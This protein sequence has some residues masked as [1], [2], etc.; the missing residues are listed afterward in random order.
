MRAHIVVGWVFEA[1]TINGWYSAN[2]SQSPP[3]DYIETC[4]AVNAWVQM[5]T[6]TECSHHQGW[7]VLNKDCKREENYM[8]YTKYKKSTLPNGL[9]LWNY[10]RHTLLPPL[11]LYG[12]TDKMCSW[13]EML[14]FPF[15]LKILRESSFKLLLHRSHYWLKSSD[16]FLYANFL[17]CKHLSCKFESNS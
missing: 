8:R 10:F 9:I 7:P 16:L 17:E 15:S 5:F 3:L 2:D 6:P 12:L 4:W 13:A 11:W 1:P 14:S